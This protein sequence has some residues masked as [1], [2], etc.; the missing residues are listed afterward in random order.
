MLAYKGFIF[1]TVG[2]KPAEDVGYASLA[3][4][5]A[6]STLRVARLIF[7]PTFSILKKRINPNF[8]NFDTIKKMCIFA[9]FF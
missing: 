4:G 2:R 1:V 7:H 6:H 8:V 9:G 5:Y 3:Y